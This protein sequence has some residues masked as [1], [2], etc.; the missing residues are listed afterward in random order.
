LKEQ[1]PEFYKYLQENDANLLSFGEGEED[2]EEDDEDVDEGDLEGDLVEG[3]DSDGENE[4]KEVSAKG[5]RK[6]PKE[7]E[8]IDVTEDI[9]NDAIK[10]SAEGSF[11]AVKKLL[12]IFRAACSP[13]G[14]TEEEEES[15]DGPSSSY[16]I[17]S[18]EVYQQVMVG[19][20]DNAHVAIY[21]LLEVKEL[22]KE[23]LSGL[24]KHPKWKKVQFLVLSFFRSVLH[25]LSGL[26]A[27]QKQGG[28]VAVFIITSL[29]AYI[30]LL[31][32]MPRLAKAIL[33]ALLN[34]WSQGAPPAED[35]ANVRVYAFLR[36][37]QM[38]L[39][40]PGAIPE[41]CFRSIYLKFARE[42]KTFNEATAASVNFMSKC[43][44]ELYSSD[45]VQAY[46]QAFLY[47]RQISLHLR[48]A[49]L[50]KSSESTRQVTTWQFL[51]CVRLWTR[52]VCAM[53]GAD[54]LGPL[55]FPL[56]QIMLGIMVVA[57]SSYFL[58]IR[59]HLISCLHQLAASTQCFIPTASR[60]VEILE[61]P[62]LFSK[63]MASTDVPP[64]LQ[65]IVKFP[66]DSIH[67]VA[68]R[69]LIVQEVV[70]LLR[71]DSE[72]Y[73]YHVGLPE[74]TYMT[75]RKLRAFIKKAKV[76]KWRD[77]ART[78]AGQLEQQS[79]TVKKQ[80]VQ[81]GKAPMEIRDFEPL[82][83]TGT[84]N[85]ATRLA[86]LVAAR[87]HISSGA[88]EIQIGANNNS[89]GKG[90]NNKG[91]KKGTQRDDEDDLS[92]EDDFSEG[93]DGTDD[94][95]DDD[96]DDDEEEE[97]QPK[98]KKQ[99]VV[100]AKNGKKNVPQKKTVNK[101]AAAPARAADKMDDEVN[102]LD[103]SDDEE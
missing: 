90:S 102:R 20:T 73:R 56:A 11:V 34:L 67:K 62:D 50:K 65:F 43:I 93:D 21:K 31:S 96:D 25:T 84:P 1:D 98:G 60:L 9:L 51:N 19:V 77:L 47:I 26:S 79:A 16:T 95:D 33:N 29:E 86:K 49:F 41:E 39:V 92:E 12:S 24:G 89:K 15:E 80:R 38:A 87:V 40:L 52:V 70:N 5:K 37:R 57:S 82:L 81:L 48:T 85:A 28:E 10:R 68:V 3:S 97:V 74:Y 91:G 2:D 103:W 45:P 53:P 17:T 83:P 18:P 99:K 32:P 78:V 42:C 63:P 59:L 100:P 36:I 13:T 75:V 35:E 55:A 76:S 71:N 54:E 58:P 44:G 72:I 88:S 69:D 101:K 94:D 61:N 6:T 27:A 8:I 7:R 46:Q 66:P 22:S 30:P 4:E 64:K 23:V 14:T